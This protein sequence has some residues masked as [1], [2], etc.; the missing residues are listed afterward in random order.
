MK[1]NIMVFQNQKN[2][3]VMVCTPDGAGRVLQRLECVEGDYFNSGYMNGMPITKL[4]EKELEN[5]DPRRIIYTHY[6]NPNEETFDQAVNRVSKVS[7]LPLAVP[8]GV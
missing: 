2:F 4:S 8:M 3:D 7:D 6:F 5:L 1:K